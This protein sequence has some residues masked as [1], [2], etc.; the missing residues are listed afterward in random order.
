MNPLSKHLS[1][2]LRISNPALRGLWTAVIALVFGL[3]APFQ[4]LADDDVLQPPQKIESSLRTP[5]LGLYPGQTMVVTVADVAEESPGGMIVISFFDLENNLLGQADGILRPGQPV[6]AALD[7]DNLGISGIRELVR[8]QID[9][10]ASELGAKPTTTIERLDPDALV[11][12]TESSY[13]GPPL[14]HGVDWDCGGGIVIT[15]L[16]PN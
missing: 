12:A 9:A 16:S 14:D 4:A 13:S 11:A 15:N 2:R 10:F 1:H 7:S 6:M 5:Y 8:V 3:L